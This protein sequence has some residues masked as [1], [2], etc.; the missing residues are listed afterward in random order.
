[1]KRFCFFIVIF[2]FGFVFTSFA[3]DGPNK[4]KFKGLYLGMPVEKAMSVIESKVGGV[5]KV[6]VDSEGDHL[7][8]TEPDKSIN[9]NA[10]FINPFT[11]YFGVYFDKKDK[12]VTRFVLYYEWV[13]KL[14]NSRKM[15]TKQFIYNFYKA[16]KIPT[17]SFNGRYYEYVSPH[18]WQLQ[19]SDYKDLLLEF[20]SKKQKDSKP[21]FD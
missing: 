6:G 14:F 12:K 1:M 3:D 15:L 13:D 10:E 2:Y 17:V 21:V 8:Y 20:L 16:Y 5:W 9:H 7:Y 11:K 19:I 4:I 18:G